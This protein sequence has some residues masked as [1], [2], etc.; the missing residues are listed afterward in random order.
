MGVR[1]WVGRGGFGRWRKGRALED[2][3]R[4]R[5]AGGSGMT[6]EELIKPA[7]GELR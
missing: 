3:H 6:F 1:T 4:K 7:D 5:R 2:L